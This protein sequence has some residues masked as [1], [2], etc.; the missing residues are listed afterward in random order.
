MKLPEVGA[1]LPGDRDFFNLTHHLELV[2]AD[3]VPPTSHHI[4]P[5]P[6][7][8]E[9]RPKVAEQS[10][11]TLPTTKLALRKYLLEDQT[12]TDRAWI[13]AYG[14][15]GREK[16]ESREAFIRRMLA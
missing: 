5:V 7:A 2:A 10:K 13:E 15:P 3:L 16:G 4:C 8:V 12:V 1:P 6:R 11:S 9:R 14:S